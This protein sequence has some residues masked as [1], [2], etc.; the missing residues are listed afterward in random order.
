MEAQSVERA[1]E[2][3]RDFACVR[4]LI[5]GLGDCDPEVTSLANGRERMAIDRDPWES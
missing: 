3:T 1:V 2:P 5:E 4:F